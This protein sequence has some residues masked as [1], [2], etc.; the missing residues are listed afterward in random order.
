[1]ITAVLLHGSMLHILFNM[2][3]LYVFGPR[4]SESRGRRR[5]W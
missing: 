3:A 1:M 2:W 5:F 4:S